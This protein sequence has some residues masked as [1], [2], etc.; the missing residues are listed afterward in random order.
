MRCPSGEPTSR[1]PA[2][3]RFSSMSLKDEFRIDP[4]TVSASCRIGGVFETSR[5]IHEG[6]D[7][8][9]EPELLSLQPTALSCG[10]PQ[11]EASDQA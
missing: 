5:R 10:G 2:T 6:D 9:W 8:R 3:D 11:A 7:L 4:S 1:K